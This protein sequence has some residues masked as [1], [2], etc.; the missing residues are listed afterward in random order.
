DAPLRLIAH[1]LAIETNVLRQAL[2]TMPDVTHL[3]R[4][5]LAFRIYWWLAG[6]LGRNFD[7]SLV[8]QG[9]YRIQIAGIS[10]KPKALCFEGQGSSTGKGIVKRGQLVTVKNLLC[11]RVIH[12]FDTGASPALPNF[13]ACS[14]Q[15][16]FVSRVFPLD[17]R[18][19]DAK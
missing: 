1:P 15:H 2:S 4:L 17:Q 8:D 9:G 14:L 16:L 12:I 7:H 3:L 18:F 11:P 10:I 19:D 13:I 5:L 6:K